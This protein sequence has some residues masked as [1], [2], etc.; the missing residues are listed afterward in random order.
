MKTYVTRWSKEKGEYKQETTTAETLTGYT[1]CGLC[2]SVDLRL[3]AIGGSDTDNFCG[4]WDIYADNKGTLYSIA[5][6]NSG[7][8][9]SYFGDCDHVKYLMRKGYFHDTLTP[10]GRQLMEGGTAA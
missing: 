8:G 9:N 10:Y 7:A 3:F 2:F 4:N 5:R 1:S 6:P